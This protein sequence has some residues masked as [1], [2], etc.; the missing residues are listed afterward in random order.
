[1][2]VLFYNLELFQCSRNGQELGAP[3]IAA[4]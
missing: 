4:S 3:S 1:M 2:Q